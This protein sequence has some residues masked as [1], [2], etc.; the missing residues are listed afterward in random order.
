M[1]SSEAERVLAELTGKKLKVN[2][3]HSVSGGCISSAWRISTDNEQYF[4]KEANGSESNLLKAEERGLQELA[5]C[6]EVKS[7]LC[8]GFLK[9]ESKGYLLL[10]FLEL[11]SH[12]PQSQSLLGTQLATMHKRTAK[13]HGFYED[14]YIGSQ[15]QINTWT[16]CWLEF[17]INCRLMPQVN[18]TKNT[19]IIQKSI[20]L[21]NKLPDFFKGYSPSPS[22]LHGDLWSG[23]T[24]SLSDA[25]PV[26][27]DPATYY[28]DR[29]TD[30]A[31]TEM[32][33]GFTSGFYEAYSDNY[34]LHKGY[35]QRKILYQ[36]YHY[37]NH[38]NIFGGSYLQKAS[39]ILDTLIS[40]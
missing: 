31:F 40:K 6:S 7:P 36:L 3:V 5:L 18:N 13:K 12:C 21:S 27:F 1:K 24:A 19:A 16:G 8:Y 17:F 2:K 22:L 15:P 14:N 9:A 32:F 25:T 29:E 39:R 4:L 26:I 35:Q 37:L 30:I 38:A 23:N 10:E 34:P 33:G 20:K 28:G 11:K